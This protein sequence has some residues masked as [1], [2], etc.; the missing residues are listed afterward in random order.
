VTSWCTCTA[1]TAEACN[2]VIAV[3]YKINHAYNKQYVSPACTS[4][5]QGWNKGTRKE[6][7]PSKV[8]DLT[9]RKDKKTKKVS[10]KNPG[11]DQTLRKEFDPRKPEDRNIT[12]ERVSLLLN[13]I[14]DTV[15]SACVLLS[16]DYG[17]G[18]GL[19]LPLTKKALEFMSGDDT[20]NMS[21]EEAV[22]LFIQHCQLSEDQV[23]SIEAAT[24]G[25]HSN[26]TWKEQRVG[27]ITASNFHTISTKTQTLMRSTKKQSQKPRYTPLVD[28]MVNGK[29]KDLSH[30]PQI[31]W[32]INH[33]KDAIRAFMSDIATQHEGG[34]HG[35]R[36]CGLFVKSGYPYL[37]GSPDGLFQCKCC[38]PATIEVKCPY[39]VKDAA[40]LKKDVY[41]RVEFL[42]DCNGQP[43]L[44]KTHKY[45]TQVQAQMWICNVNHCFFI[46]WTE[47][48]ADPVVLLTDA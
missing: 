35:F 41:T 16:V 6:V 18:S 3:L 22:P 1:G 4:V 23:K 33:E 5:P 15:P 11:H 28:E 45:F 47:A 25:Q 2:H 10:K 12:D 48:G 17:G 30:L 32:G 36:Q 38:S 37:A 39:S 29:G 13:S 24:R 27:R 43:R 31:A 44:K 20:K 40:I 14:V 8:K 7:N 9:F 21:L 19:P 34:L 42:E 26:I 46:V